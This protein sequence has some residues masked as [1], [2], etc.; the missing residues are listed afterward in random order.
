LATQP[1][2]GE[3][4]AL[5]EDQLMAAMGGGEYKGRRAFV[6]CL[7]SVAGSFPTLSEPMRLMIRWSAQQMERFGRE[8]TELESMLEKVGQDRLSVQTLKRRRGIGTITA[9]GMVAE[10]IDVRRFPAEDNLA[11]YSGL[12]KVQDNSGE[13]E[14]MQKALSYNRR[15]K[16]L[17]MSA[18]MNVVRFDPDSHL[19]GYHRNLVKR[20]M[21]EQEAT[22]RVARALVRVIYR[23]LMGLV[24]AKPERPAA[25]EQEEGQSGVASGQSRSDKRHLS[26]TPP[27]SPRTSKARRQAPVKRTAKRRS[28]G[29]VVNGGRARLKESA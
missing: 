20:G 1:Q 18:A 14:R 4:K 24:E 27:R 12:G 7:Q 25:Q 6:R 11:S 9:T 23:E 26:N 28:S 19:A 15:L 29:K 8:Q 16:D 3:W 2:I 5:S 10:M 13:R 22:K 17:F 21:Q